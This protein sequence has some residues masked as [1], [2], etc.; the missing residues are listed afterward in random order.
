MA[1]VDGRMTRRAEG[2][3]VWLGVPTSVAPKLLVVDFEIRYRAA[4]LTPPAIATQHLLPQLFVRGGIN[5]H[6]QDLWVNPV[7]DA[8]A[9]RLSRKPCC[10][11]GARN[12]KNLVIENNSVS[13]SPWSR[14][15]PARKSAQIIS[16]Q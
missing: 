7:H 4:R 9:V 6:R 3:Q 14:L 8:L 15:A 16:K 13:G 12:R 11:S 5:S 2:N 10:C 1:A